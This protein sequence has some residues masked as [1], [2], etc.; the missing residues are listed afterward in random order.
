LA[1]RRSKKKKKKRYEKGEGKGEETTQQ[2]KLRNRRLLSF[3]IGGG[4]EN[5]A[6]IQMA[7]E[8]ELKK[9]KGQWMTTPQPKRNRDNPRSP[10]AN[11]IEVGQ[12]NKVKGS[13][14]RQYHK[15]KKP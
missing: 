8:M 3:R 1:V 7:I 15:E 6:S 5:G 4:T 12:S 10:E 11:T 14:S 2:P 13:P 9:K